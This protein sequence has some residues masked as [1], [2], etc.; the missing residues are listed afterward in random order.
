MLHK[1]K[2]WLGIEGLKIELLIPEEV[3]ASSG[4]ID[5]R[6]VFNTK[7]LQTVQDITIQVFE[8]YTRG[9]GKEQKI[10][11]FEIGSIS[12]ERAL[13]IKA[14][15]ETYIDFALPF[16]LHHSNMD[17]F[18]SKNVIS[19]GLAK[20]AKAI[21][22]VKSEYRVVATAQVTGTA[23]NPFDEKWLVIK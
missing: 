21:H 6:I 14:F 12:F 9:R 22:Q 13:E 8:K 3:A 5:G 2:N 10:D 15:E 16:Q 19:K 4:F 11:E 20:A 23:L 18:G 17:Q 1:F 7:Q